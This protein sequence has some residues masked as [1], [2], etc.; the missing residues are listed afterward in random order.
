MQYYELL[1]LLLCIIILLYYYYY[2]HHFFI[3]SDSIN[4]FQFKYF[5]PKNIKITVRAILEPV[6]R[7]GIP[8][9][10]PH[11]NSSKC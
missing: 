1:R 5:T 10:E 4:I 3:I 2:H 11:S 6:Y 9:S 8:N 7:F